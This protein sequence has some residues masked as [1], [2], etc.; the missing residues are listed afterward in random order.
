MLKTHLVGKRLATQEKDVP[1]FVTILPAQ[2]YI[3]CSISGALEKDLAKWND[4]AAKFK[5]CTSPVLKSKESE[6]LEAIAELQ[7]KI[8]VYRDYLACLSLL[9]P[10]A[11]TEKMLN[12]CGGYSEQAKK[13]Q[14]D[15][16]TKYKTLTAM[17]N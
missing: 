2:S 11:A 10:A 13:L 16:R 12:S 9:E 7:E 3:V 5:L 8:Q 14:A 17:L 15:F 6:C 1:L 4:L